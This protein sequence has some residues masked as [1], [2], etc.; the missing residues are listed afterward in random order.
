[1]LGFSIKKNYRESIVISIIMF[2]FFIIHIGVSDDETLN[3]AGSGYISS[4]SH[5]VN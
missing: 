5:K 3:F 1:L 4:F 2:Q